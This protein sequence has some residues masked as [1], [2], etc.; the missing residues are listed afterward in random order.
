MLS[1]PDAIG[2]VLEKVLEVQKES[3][4]EEKPVRHH[5]VVRGESISQISKKISVKKSDCPEC[6]SEMEHEGGC[7]VCRSCGYSKCG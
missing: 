5:D 2:R 6:G 7:S 4:P 1:C 3:F